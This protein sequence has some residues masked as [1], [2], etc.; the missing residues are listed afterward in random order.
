LLA[1]ERRGGAAGG[2]DLRTVREMI[3]RALDDD[4][5]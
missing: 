5:G 1:A 2:G 3:A 4:R